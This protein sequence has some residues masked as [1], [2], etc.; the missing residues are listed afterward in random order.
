MS[1]MQVFT[2]HIVEHDGQYAHFES[3]GDAERYMRMAFD[4]EKDSGNEDWDISCVR[5]EERVEGDSWSDALARFQ[6]RHFDY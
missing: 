6:F 2:I 5:T 4:Y 1:D 3:P